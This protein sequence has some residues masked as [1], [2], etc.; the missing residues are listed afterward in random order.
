MQKKILIISYKT[1]INSD[2]KNMLIVFT[3]AIIIYLCLLFAMRLMG[4]K[5]LGELQPFEFAVTLVAAE[6]AC[7]PMSDTTVP[8]FYGLI[9]IFTLFVIHLIL[10]KIIKHSIKIRRVINGKPI[11]IIDSNGINYDAISKLDMTVNDLLES[12]RGCGYFSPSEV[13]YAIV[14]TNGDLTVVPKAE[15]APLTPA[16]MGIKTDPKGIPYVLICEGK[17]LSQNM[18]LSGI[19]N[20]FID[21]LLQKYDLKQKN[22]LMASV[23]NNENVFLQ[24]IKKPAINTSVKEVVN[25]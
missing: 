24:P 18:Q 10:T 6:L 20:D 21:K 9:P 12:L 22:V 7:I 1:A 5:Q 3:R 15:N 13:Q 8:I 4:K 17:I 14:E 23:D 11:I 19:R 25:E 16:D 2:T